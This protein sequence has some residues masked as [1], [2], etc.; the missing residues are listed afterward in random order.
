MNRPNLILVAYYFPPIRSAGSNRPYQ[1]ARYMRARGR[2]VAV[3]KAGNGPSDLGVEERWVESSRLRVKSD[4]ARFALAGLVGLYR[5][6]RAAWQA[7]ALEQA[8]SLVREYV[9]A[10]TEVYCSYPITE[11]L[12]VGL[13]LKRRYPELRLTVEYRD[14]LATET[15]EGAKS[16]FLPGARAAFARLEDETLKAADT[17]I[18]VSAILSAA[19]SAKAG[20]RTVLTAM[21]GFSAPALPPTP[22][23]VDAIRTRV[24]P[25]STVLL[26]AGSTI[27]KE[28]CFLALCKGIA[29]HNRVTGT[30]RIALA[31]LGETTEALRRRV[32]SRYPGIATFLPAVGR[33]EA[34]ALQ[35]QAG[36]L[37]ILSLDGETRKGIL[38]GKLFE[39]LFAGVPILCL[40]PGTEAALVI[41]ETGTGVSVPDEG[42]ELA[43]ALLAAG[44][45]RLPYAPRNLERYTFESQLGGLGT[46]WDA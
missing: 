36:A 35:R 26:H 42:E 2:R 29:R 41:A 23:N 43:A 40:M 11:A 24:F 5:P 15:I 22:G 21:N 28:R 18:T 8:A 37:V 20:G 39:Y 3:V 1:V 25:D 9:A 30:R 17:V 19:L 14:G 31:Q 7:W 34:V 6:Q 33:A 46:Y 4:K 16:R 32:E 10:E 38:T 45:G 12:S 13:E 27:R 44:A